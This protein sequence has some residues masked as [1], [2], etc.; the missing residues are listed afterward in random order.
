MKI[1]I[2]I[3][4]TSLLVACVPTDKQKSSSL[5]K[6]TT[7]VSSSAS[8]NGANTAKTKATT[9]MVPKTVPKKKLAPPIITNEET[10]SIQKVLETVPVAA[11]DADFKR[12]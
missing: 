11:P 5:V 6:S 12:P 1:C 7:K 8:S 4:V 2:Y 3:L 9:K 10:T